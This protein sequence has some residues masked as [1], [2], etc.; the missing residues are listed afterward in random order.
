MK[1]WS[2]TM[3]SNPTHRV[4]ITGMGAISPLGNTV[5][6][7]WS[8]LIAGRS[9]IGS[10]TL[11]DI[12]DFPY[13]I[14]AEVKNF[15]PRD[16]MDFKAARR[17]ARFAQFAVAAAGEALRDSELDLDRIDQT[18]IAV[19]IGTGLGGSAVT[20]EE[21]LAF[22][23]KERKRLNN[24]LYLPIYIANMAACQVAM[25]YGLHGPT[26]A[27]VAACATG[28]YA[29]GEA[30]RMVHRGDALLAVTGGTDAGVTALNSMAFG[31]I[32]AIAPAG[33][34]PTKAVRPFDANRKG[35]AG[36]EGCGVFIL[37][38]ME[39]AL[40]RDAHIYAEVV[41]FGATEDAFHVTAPE[42]NATYSSLAITRA[43]EDAELSPEDVDYIS[44]HGTGTP[45]NDEAETVAIKKALG[46]H[47]YNVPISA[48]KS[49]LGHTAG[50]AGALALIGCVKTIETGIIPPTLNYTIADPKCD[51]DYVPNIARHDQHVDV[52]LT[53]AF[54]FGGQNAVVVVRRFEN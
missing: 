13:T 9:G 30:A 34:D 42:P 41:G 39:L 37:E 11:F 54:G 10:V 12:T 21:S 23:R 33:D 50:A 32:G 22:I 44:A 29:V 25:V 51:L 43:L 36:G 45:I 19:D 38:Q 48:V 6:D 20:E 7:M 24:T 18:R 52:A 5:A 15:D 47:A 2:K 4:V 3:R 46:D 14:A 27:P 40:A 8:G 35:T 1:L 28:A 16:H 49:M 17:M 53:S 31:V 26:T